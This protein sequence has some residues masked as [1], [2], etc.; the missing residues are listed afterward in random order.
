MM[1]A[2]EMARPAIEVQRERAERLLNGVRAAVLAVA[3]ARRAR[4]RA[5]HPALRA[6]RELGGAAA[7]ARLVASAVLAR[8]APASARQAVAAVGRVRESARGYHGG[9]GDSRWLQL[10]A[11][12]SAGAQV[13]DLSRV[14]RD[15]RRASDRLVHAQ[16][17]CGGDARRG[18]VQHARRACCSWADAS[19]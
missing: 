11:P 6:A 16:G 7:D 4:V 14:L 8:R 9:D 5:A 18:G 3:R 2:M 12:G 10:C 1:L 19:R 15:S 13:A 17:R